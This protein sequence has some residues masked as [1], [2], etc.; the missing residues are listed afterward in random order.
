MSEA[1]EF[2]ESYTSK[3]PGA[4]RIEVLEGWNVAS[5]PSS[6]DMVHITD[7]KT[8]WNEPRQPL[9]S[10]ICCDSRQIWLDQEPVRI[11]YKLSGTPT[12]F[13]PEGLANPQWQTLHLPNKPGRY[14]VYVTTH[15]VF[16]RG[17]DKNPYDD[18]GFPVSSNILELQVK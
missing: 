15:R 1:V 17:S 18:A 11:P 5:N 6:S 16:E 12:R 3:W 13:N 2:E 8:V 14:R 4:W 9:T 7:G 10:I